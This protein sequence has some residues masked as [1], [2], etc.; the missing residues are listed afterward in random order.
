M[1][2]NFYLLPQVSSNATL[3]TSAES[4]DLGENVKT[5]LKS[6]THRIAL[7]MLGL[8]CALVAY[9]LFIGM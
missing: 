5:T 3:S 6:N 1:K 4:D 7:I 2:N 9:V 8:F